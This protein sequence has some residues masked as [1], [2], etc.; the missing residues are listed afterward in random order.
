[1]QAPNNHLLKLKENFSLGFELNPEEKPKRFEMG[2]GKTICVYAG[3]NEKK[4]L[5]L[6][7]I[8]YGED[9]THNRYTFYLDDLEKLYREFIERVKKLLLE[10]R[11]GTVVCVFK[12]HLSTFEERVKLG[13]LKNSNLT[14]NVSEFLESTK[15]I[16][17][18]EVEVLEVEKGFYAFKSML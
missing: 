17:G 16:A 5:A 8:C 7:L 12:V 15:R 3:K 6:A 9:D 4:G 2:N 14:K 18:H 11:L 13:E 10:E 1:M